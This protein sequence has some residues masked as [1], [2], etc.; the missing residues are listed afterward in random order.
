MPAAH[1][2]HRARRV[3]TRRVDTP[4]GALVR[5][6]R[7]G[8]RDAA[9]AL[10][11]RYWDD[12]WRAAYAITGRVDLADDVAQDAFERAFLHLDR[13]DDRRPFRPWLHRIVLNRTLDLL[14]AERRRG[15]V[16]ITPEIAAPLDDTGHGPFMDMVAGLPLERRIPVVLRYLLDYT[17]AEIAELTDTPVGTIGSRISRA[18]ADLRATMEVER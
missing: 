4:D 17:P 6:A 13:L 3:Y 15:A 7:R 10:A 11:E 5:A 9:N 12:A 14:R 2:V 1:P 18:L 8:D 16:E